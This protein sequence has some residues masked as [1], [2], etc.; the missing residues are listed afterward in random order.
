MNLCLGAAEMGGDLTIA[1]V[2]DCAGGPYFRR[3]CRKGREGRGEEIKVVE[4][5]RVCET[6]GRMK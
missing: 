3:R 4:C 6:P 5:E 2:D 1:S